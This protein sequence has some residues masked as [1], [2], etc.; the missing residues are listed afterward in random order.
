MASQRR[1]SGSPRAALESTLTDAVASA[2]EVAA[3]AEL[4]V[5]RRCVGA[6]E[7]FGTCLRPP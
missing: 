4:G 6:G 5:G 7:A 1:G 2:T 3:E